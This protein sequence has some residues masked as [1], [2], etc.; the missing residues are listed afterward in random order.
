MND[1]D[2]QR[3]VERLVELGGGIVV[4]SDGEVRAELPLPVAGL[5]S[6]RPLAEVVA[7]SRA[8]VEAAREL[9]CTLPSPFQ[10]LAFLALSVIPSLKITDHGLVDVDALRA[11]AARGVSTLYANAHV[12]TLD[13]ARSEHAGGWLLVEDGFVR[14]VGAGAEPESDERVDLG[15]KVVTPGLVNTHHHLYQTLTRARAQEADLFTWLRELYPVWA[16]IDAEAEYAAARTGLAELALSGCT[17][18]FDH[19]YVFPR[20]RTGLVEAEVQ[21]ARELGVRIVASRGSMDL[22]ESDGGLPPDELVEDLDAVLADTERLAGEL[23]E[24]GPGARVQLAVAPCSPFSVTGKLM[25][26]SAALARRLG[27]PLHTHLAETVEEDAYCRELYGCTP[28]EYL[29]RLGWLAGDVWCAHCVHLRDEEIRRFGETGTGVAHCPTSNLRL[30]AGVAP[31]RELLDADVRVGLG[32]D[33]SASNE[34]SDLFFEVKQALLVARGRGGPEAMTVRDALALGARGGAAVL[35]RDDIGSLEPGKCADFAVWRVDGLEL[36][37][38][39]DLVAGLVLS[40]P[41]R[42][43]RLVRRRRGRRARRAP[44]QG[45]RGRDRARARAAKRQDSRHEPLHP[46]PR[47][48]ARPSSGR[49][50]ASSCYRGDE[51]LA[52]AADRRRRPDRRP[53]AGPRAGRLPDRLP[54]AVAVLPPRRARGGA[55][56]R[57][58]ARPAPRLVLRVRELPRQLSVDELAELFEGRSRFVERLAELPDPL[59]AAFDLVG[60]LPEDELVEALERAPRRSARRTSPSARRAE[61]GP[62]DER[63]AS[64]P[65]SRT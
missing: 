40:A 59:E 35:G 16:R 13:D 9:G 11:R 58:H 38:A 36:G 23:H 12:V 49:A 24:P 25:E 4:V 34:R 19:H 56:R 61:Q 15:G 1:D 57:A 3:A 55:R 41:H 6:D 10:S 7:A 54:P 45:R 21:A 22:G 31:V 29:E 65:S 27:L 33:G 8:C 52:D 20:G 26:E 18:V 30:G 46:R 63:R 32:V 42:V 50:F 64:R 14:D 48:R 44:R 51:Q 43:D 5:L 17:T 53:R 39:E 47:H 62:D 2:L 60:E 28:V 37:G